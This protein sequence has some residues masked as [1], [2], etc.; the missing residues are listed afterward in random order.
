MQE[1]KAIHP[2][3]IKKEKPWISDW[4]RKQRSTESRSHDNKRLFFWSLTAALF[5]FD[6]VVISGAEK[7]IQEL[8]SLGNFQH[9]LAIVQ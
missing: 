1:T 7:T 3:L 2:V 4:L 6:T 8:W 5:G 9:G